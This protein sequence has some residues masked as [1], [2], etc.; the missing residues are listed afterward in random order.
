MVFGLLTSGVG[1]I[2][3]TWEG[4]FLGELQQRLFQNTLTQFQLHHVA[5]NGLDKSC[6]LRRPWMMNPFKPR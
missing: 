6:S 4:I 2:Y 5:R 3:D 1:E